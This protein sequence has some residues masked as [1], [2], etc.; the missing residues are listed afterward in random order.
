MTETKQQAAGLEVRPT[1]AALGAEIVG[2]DLSRPLSDER[3]ASI[4]AA[5]A[6]HLVLLLRDQRISDDDLIGFARRFG[7]LHLATGVEYGGKPEDLRDAV[8][9]ISNIERDGRPIGAL[10]ADEATWHTDM[11]MY[12][13]PAS[14]TMLL[15]E[16][17]PPAGG[18][19][20]FTNLYRAYETLP[21]DLRRIVEGRRSIHDHAYLASGGVRPGF[22]AVTDKSQGPGARHPIVRTNP[23][24]G[25]KALY[26]GR[27]G[28]G[29]ILD[30]PVAESDRVIDALW[31]HMTRPEFV[32]EHRWRV[33][34]LV[35]W[36][37][38]CVAH[39]RGA[40]DPK[41]RRLLRRVTVKSEVPV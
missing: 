18:N 39:A 26:L 33:G 20:R 22:E 28:N 21:D 34:D 6:D 17:I 37:N 16:E 29:Y 10:G 25:R 40:F 1:G 9:L 2:V 30:L 23:L 8:E 4:E 19:T 5:W 24:T 31:A 35:M 38:R 7:E 11:S 12:E 32:W 13:I 36:D 27:M 14:A 15:A 3:F 41:S